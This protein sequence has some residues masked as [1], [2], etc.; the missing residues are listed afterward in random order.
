MT[1][2]VPLFKPARPIASA[3]KAVDAVLAT[4]NRMPTDEEVAM[5]FWDCW[6]SHGWITLMGLEAMDAEREAAKK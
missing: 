2:I 4:K 3:L 1:K 5:A 6:V